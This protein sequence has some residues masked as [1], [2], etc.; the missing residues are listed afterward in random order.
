MT[1]TVILIPHTETRNGLPIHSTWLLALE[2]QIKLLQVLQ[3]D[4]GLLMSIIPKAYRTS[5]VSSRNEFGICCGHLVT[6]LQSVLGLG[7]YSGS[8]LFPFP[9]AS[10]IVLLLTWHT[11]GSSRAIVLEHQHSGSS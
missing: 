10:Q 1:P 8:W 11:D 7:L 3:N 5:K 6:W 2:L 9:A 4:L